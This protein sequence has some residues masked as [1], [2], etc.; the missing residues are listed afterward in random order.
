MSDKT[1]VI[2][3]TTL[4]P[5][6]EEPPSRSSKSA[7]RK[8]IPLDTTEVTNI[9]EA[10]KEI[11]RLQKQKEIAKLKKEIFDIEYDKKV[12]ELNAREV[13]LED[14]WSKLE[15]AKKS[16]EGD[17]QILR[18]QEQV[19][20]RA[21]KAEGQKKL[22]EITL[23][24]KTLV[25]WQNDA[26]DIIDGIGAILEELQIAEQIPDKETWRIG[27]QTLE[28]LRANWSRIVVK[29]LEL[30]NLPSPILATDDIEEYVEDDYIQPYQPPD[31]E[32]DDEDDVEEEED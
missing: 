32:D 13:E 2:R 18:E 14:E 21:A 19:V 20:V 17:K 29:L 31:E 11:T 24:K 1:Y 15:A 30:K 22:H 23:L 8:P 26:L 27:Y 7:P 25:K 6:G 28:Q 5:K 3:G 9:T 16:F 12:V 4:Y 10:D